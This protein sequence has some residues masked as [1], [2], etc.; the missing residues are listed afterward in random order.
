VSKE[1]NLAIHRSRGYDVV[2]LTEHHPMQRRIGTSADSHSIETIAGLE[3]GVRIH[4]REYY[5]LLLGVAADAPLDDW[6][7]APRGAPPGGLAALRN[8]IARVHAANGVVLALAMNLRPA[9]VEQFVAAGLDGFELV[10]FGHPEFTAPIGA[11]LI[12]EQKA[13]GIALVAT[14]DWHGWGGMFKT[15]TV[16]R[17]PASPGNNADRVMDALRRHD[18]GRIVPVVSQMFEEPSARRVL[19]APFAEAVRYGGELSV[20]RLASWW[21]WTVLMVLAVRGL[22]RMRLNPV[23][24]FVTAAQAV[25]GVCVIARGAALVALWLRGDSMDYP[26]FVGSIAIATGALALAIAWIN[27]CFLVRSIVASPWIPD[28]SL[29][30]G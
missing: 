2:A 14:S 7:S 20:P 8:L 10:N 25:L 3:F 27:R 4:G 21:V 24:T 5:F 11:A 12:A 29:E 17:L 15:W 28:A 22:R 18:S 23:G 26:L 6:F 16:F 19:L 30:R 13:R 1:Q 9:D